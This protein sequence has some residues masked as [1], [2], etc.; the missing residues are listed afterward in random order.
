MSSAHA[1]T[2]AELERAAAFP[3]QTITLHQ[4][5]N[6]ISHQQNS[7][8]PSQPHPSLTTAASS[9]PCTSASHRLNLTPTLHLQVPHGQLR[10]DDPHDR[11]GRGEALVVVHPPPQPQGLPR[12]AGRPPPRVLLPGGS[13]R[14]P[15][16]V[17]SCALCLRLCWHCMHLRWHCLCLCW[18]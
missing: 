16:S 9:R 11:V 1:T 3:S 17:P 2:P 12:P 6:P 5:Q 15:V 10:D 4:Q 14:L 7:S 18:H 8:S 13:L